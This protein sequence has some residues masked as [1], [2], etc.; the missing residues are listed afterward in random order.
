MADRDEKD[1]ESAARRVSDAGVFLHIED[2]RA[3]LAA[4]DKEIAA[5]GFWDDASH[6]QS[7]SKQ[8]SVLRETI[9]EY[10]DAVALLDDAR[11]AFEL[12]D[13]DEA[14]AEEASNALAHLDGPARL[15]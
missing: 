3:A 8:A 12:A 11:A 1:V 10:E 7:V 4:L 14:F 13:E 9:A 2:K 15:P 6:A 5:P